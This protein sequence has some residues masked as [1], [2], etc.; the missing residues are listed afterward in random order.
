MSLGKPTVFVLMPFADD[1]YEVYT[2][3]IKPAMEAARVGA[4]CYR[5]DDYNKGTG[6]ITRDIIE[7]IVNADVVLAD[8][9]SK[10]ANVFY[11]LG[12]AHSFGQKTIMIAQSTK[13]IPFDINTFNVIV[14]EQ[15][16]S[17]AKKLKT[18]LQESAL[19]I[20]R[21][22]VWADNPVHANLGSTFSG[23][24][25]SLASFHK[26][27]QQVDHEVWI[28]GPHLQL[29]H[30]Y[31]VEIMRENIEKKK[32]I[33]K[34]IL[35]DVNT[36]KESFRELRRSVSNGKRT[37]A[38]KISGVF[39]APELIESE[40]VLYDPNSPKE[41]G[42]FM[43]PVENPVAYTKIVGSRLHEVKKRFEYLWNQ[44]LV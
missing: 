11:E 28:I 19:K 23:Q 27:E 25:F 9:T 43:P 8:L 18:M 20:I 37:I 10:N 3:V 41:S 4:N 44:A 15:S 36:V 31:F 2:D 1:F 5:V 42:F 33:Y 26:V 16:I 35:P 30:L 13:D 22:G 17:G 34:Y 12:I 38:S 40:I 6:N 39:I 14:Y 7:S 21:D 24:S 32:V 29:D